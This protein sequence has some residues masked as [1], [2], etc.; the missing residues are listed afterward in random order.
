MSDVDMFCSYFNRPWLEFTGRLLEAEIGNGWTEGVH[1]EDRTQLI[2]TRTNCYARREP[3]QVEYRIRRI[4][5]QYRWILNSCVPRFESDGRFAGYIGSAIDVTERKLAE[6]ALSMVSRKLIEAHEEERTWLARELHDD[7][8]QRLVSLILNLGWLRS[9]P[10]SSLDEVREGIG[11]VM[12]EASKLGSDMQALSHRLHTSKLEYLGLTAAAADF[13]RELADQHRVKIEVQS[14]NIPGGLAQ[15][16]SLSV[17][18]VLQEALQNGLKH[19]GSK[20]FHV[21]LQ[22]KSNVLLLSVRDEGIGFETS[23]V[24]TGRGLGLTSMKE[25][26][27]L[28]AG[29][30]RIESQPGKGTTIHVRVPIVSGTMAAKS[31]KRS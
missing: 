14:E 31:A 28:V 4:D 27:K 15:D 5:G 19:S 9:S 26:I 23:N 7:I 29:E 10:K 8:G 25:R 20:R 12:Q 3:F 6:E 11:Q 30:L 13:C 18:R 1:P 24:L 16:I 17:F 21:S 2:D 22:G